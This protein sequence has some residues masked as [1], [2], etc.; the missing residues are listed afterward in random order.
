MAVRRAQVARRLPVDPLGILGLLAL[1]A[2]WWAVTALGLVSRVFLPPPTLVAKAVADNLFSSPYFESYSV[3][4]GGIAG[5]L[6]YTTTNILIA[7]GLACVLGIVLGLA[8]ARLDLVRAVLDP[9]MLTV[10]TLPVLVMAPFFLIWFATDRAAQVLLLFVYSVTIIYLFT[11]RA[12]A[13]LDPIYESA[14]RT[15]GA[16]RAKILRDVYLQGTLPEVLGGIRIALAGA[17]GL[18]AIAE[19]LGAPR[20]VGRVIQALASSSDVPSIMATVLVLAVVAVAF[21]AIVAGLFGY[22]TRWQA[23]ER[24]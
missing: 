1:F 24:V 16:S 6:I 7:L 17:W 20:G 11:Q 15:F 21:D 2:L 14:A 9:I 18:E 10:G 3:G 23:A 13:N 19:L 22:I 5:S 12:V 4:S 8:S